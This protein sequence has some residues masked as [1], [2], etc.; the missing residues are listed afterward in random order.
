MP[1]ALETTVF[2]S[3]LKAFYLEA[4][5]LSPKKIRKHRRNIILKRYYSADE[6]GISIPIKWA[7]KV[8]DTLYKD[9]DIKNVTFSRDNVYLVRGIQYEKFKAIVSDIMSRIQFSETVDNVL[10]E[11]A[12]P[13]ADLL[14]GA[15][16]LSK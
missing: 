6:S 9:H 16:N 4:R 14:P 5:N 3:V 15:E 12:E 7:Q 11:S 2:D 8:V 10:E 1:T 13:G